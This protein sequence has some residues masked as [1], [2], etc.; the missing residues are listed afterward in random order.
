DRN[1]ALLKGITA[2]YITVLTEGSDDLMNTF[3]EVRLD[4]LHDDQAVIGK[5]K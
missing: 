5:L 1:T 4:R 2:N 3:K